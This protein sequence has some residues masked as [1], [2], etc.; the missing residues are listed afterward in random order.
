MDIKNKFIF[1]VLS[2]SILALIMTAYNSNTVQ[3]AFIATFAQENQTGTLNEA[4]VNANIEQ[5]NKCK[6]DTECENENELNNSLTILNEETEGG[7]GQL[8]VIKEVTCQVGTNGDGFT[9][10]VLDDHAVVTNIQYVPI[11]ISCDDPDVQDI[12]EPQDF[13]F[14]VTG[15]N[16]NPS[17]FVGSDS[18]VVVTLGT[19]AY[20]VQETDNVPPNIGP[21]TINIETIKTGDCTGTITSGDS[22]TCTFTNNVHVI[23]PS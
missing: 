5:E 3:S 22:K 18:G 17:Q 15:N 20:D 19:G 2:F 7:T 10:M 8:T 14:T 1:A 12:I 16:P 4:E 13:E 23:L 6:K 11:G 9:G 21:Y